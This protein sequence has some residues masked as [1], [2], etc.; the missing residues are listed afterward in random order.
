V[1]RAGQD[2]GDITALLDGPEPAYSFEFFPPKTDE[3]ERQLWQAIRELEPLAPA[4]VSVTYGAGGSTRD[5]TV[6]VTARLARETALRTVAHLTCVGASRDEVRAVVGAYADAGVRAVL[7]LRGDPPGGPGT[8]FEAHPD[9]LRTATELVTLLRGL[10]DFAIGVAAF[11]EGHPESRD[12]QHD[13]RVLLAKAEAGAQFA[14]TQFFFRAEDY[15][16]LVDRVRALG[17]TLPIVPG[18]MPVTNLS[19]I[20]R[21]AQLSGTAFP[22]DLAARLEAVGDDPEAVRRVGVEAATELSRELL[23]GGAPGLHFYTLNRSTATREVH[24]ALRG[25]TVGAS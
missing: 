24:A 5:R 6:R 22:A 16:A 8:P 12:L 13:A 1:D 4:F 11:P 9:G 25:A 2:Q 10:G 15:F 23:A 17:A 3:G 20:R 19:Q 21:F 7:A 18:V 14:I